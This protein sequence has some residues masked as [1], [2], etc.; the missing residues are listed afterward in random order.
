MNAM[1]P[2]NGGRWDLFVTKLNATGSKLVY[3]TY[4]GGSGAEW[5]MGYNTG[6][7]KNLAVDALGDAFVTGGTES[8]DFPVLNPLQAAGAGYGDA[9]VAELGPTGAM[10]YATYLGGVSQDYAAGIAV[11]SAG[12]AFV[13]GNTFSYK[14]PATPAAP[15]TNYVFYTR[16]ILA[17]IAPYTAVGVSPA[18]LTFNGRLVGNPSPARKVSY[19][20]KGAT[21]VQFNRIYFVGANA[22]DFAETDTCGTSL[23]PGAACNVSV[24]F[25]PAIAGLRKGALAFSDSDPGSPHAIALTGTGTFLAEAPGA[26]AFGAQAVST[27]SVPQSITLTNTGGSAVSFYSIRVT[28]PNAGDFSLSNG[29]GTMLAAGTSCMVSVTFKPA[30][31]GTRQGGVYVGLVGGA[32]PAKLAL[33]GNGF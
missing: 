3:S 32:N 31:A 20:N 21:A 19:S 28:G 5:G 11:D 17:K 25:T 30:A 27:A 7:A 29:C 15:F 23:A 33:S 18:Q 6:A 9:F 16:T 14:F 1:Q 26:L 4:L 2:N 12:S 13:T 8:S 10:V 22:G 24:T